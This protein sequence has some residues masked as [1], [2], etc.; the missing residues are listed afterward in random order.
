MSQNNL[1][2]ELGTEELP[3][4]SLRNLAQSLHDNFTQSLRKANFTFGDSHWYATPR[5]LALIISSIEDRQPDS[6]EQIKGPSLKAAYNSDGTPTKAALG[7]AT[8]NKIDLSQAKTLNT[9]KGSWLYIDVLKQGAKLAELVPNLFEQALKALPIP[10]LM[11]WGNSDIEFVRPVHTLTM[12]Y[13]DE[14]I[15]GT[16][17]GLQSNRLIH[18]HRFLGKSK[19]EVTSAQTYLSQLKNEGHVI[20]DYNERKSLIVSQLENINRTLNCHADMDDSLIE[21]V[22]SIVEFPQ[23]YTASFPDSFLQVPPEALVYTMKG[24]QKYFPLYDVNGK[25]MSTFAFIS[26]INPD[27]AETLIKGNERVIRPRLSDAEFFFKTDRKHKLSDFHQKL[28]SIIYQKDIGTIAQRSEYVS[29]LASIIAKQIN[30]DINQVN[31]AAYLY[32][33]DLASTMVSEFPETQG[34]IGKHYAE[35]DSED[36][37]VS[38]AIFESYQPRFAGDEIPHHPVGCALSIADKIITLVSIFGIGLQPKGDRDPYG[39]RRA[40]NGV[41]RI[42]LENKLELKLKELLS[43]AEQILHEKLKD[44]DSVAKVEEFIYNRLKTYFNDKK[45]DTQI[46]LSVLSKKPASLTDFDKRVKAVQNFKLNSA[47]QSLALAYKRINNILAKC[48]S[49]RNNSI[50]S[51]LFNDSAEHSLYK[52]MNLLQPQLELCFKEQNYEKGFELM[53]QLKEPVDVFFDNVLVNDENTAVK[54]NRIALLKSLRALLSTTAD[55][56]VLY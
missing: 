2:L 34:S 8:A 31:R 48:D 9:D 17:L 30:A 22:T 55:I 32:K 53:S 54:N 28:E 15:P 44:V 11:H 29:K 35:L 37:E 25:L 26:N 3:P 52:A 12:L 1:L 13:G 24:D 46:F 5:R 39:L 4:K 14:L 16:V 18:G 56:S 33:C 45:I 41:I 36:K 19:F 42:I 20:A 47:S 43:N 21:E 27:N 23:I 40:A 10:K 51:D 49:E 6:Q 38:A 7:W 50:D